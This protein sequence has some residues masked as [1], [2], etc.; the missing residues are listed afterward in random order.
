M[1]I[2][3]R[4]DLWPCIRSGWANQKQDRIKVSRIG[5]TPLHQPTCF[6]AT[7]GAHR[8]NWKFE[9]IYLPNEIIHEMY[10]EME[11]TFVRV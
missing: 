11:L 10:L 8:N 1:P 3:V 6:L 4:F 9:S 7:G 5:S 2:L